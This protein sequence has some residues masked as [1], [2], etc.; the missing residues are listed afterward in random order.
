MDEGTLD[1]WCAT[2]AD[3]MRQSFG[4]AISV[5]GGSFAQREVDAL[6]L[7]NELVRGWLEGE[8]VRMATSYGRELRVD[9]QLYREHAAGTRRYHTL[10]G[11]VE[12]H[13]STYRRA[14]VH[15]GPTVVP[16]ELEAGI[17]E[18]AT[19]A[20]ALSAAQAFATMPLRLYE[21]EMRAAHRV[22]P[23]RSTVERIAKRLGDGIH[24]QLH[25]I[26]PVVRASETVPA[27][28]AS[29]SV[30]VDRTT[31]PM[32]EQLPAL[33][34]YWH[35]DRARRPPP[36]VVMAYRMAY[37]ATVAIVDV[38]GEELV[39]KRLAATA[40]EGPIEM[41]E[42]LGAEL[43]HI[44]RERPRLPVV[45]VQDGAPELWNLV[46]EWFGN[47]GIPIEM[48]LLDRFHL[49]ERL[50]QVAEMIERDE[51]LRRRLLTSWRESLDR[52]D[53]A[54]RGIC[55]QIEDRIYEPLDAPAERAAFRT[56]YQA[57]GWEPE[58]TLRIGRHSGRLLEGHVAYCRNNAMKMRYATAKKRGFPIG[59]GVTEGACKSVIASRL[60]RSGQ[61]WF[62]RGASTCLQ[63]RTLHLND[64]LQSSLDLYIEHRRA[65]LE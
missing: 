9:G 31:I 40:E 13:R 60:K 26:E 19:P 6:A 10:C 62:E 11:A 20:L 27:E 61:R 12:V 46:E 43:D 55:K 33:P 54:I 34:D 29:I 63:M 7:A 22:L 48:K 23:S 18:N 38:D 57:F 64:R 28:A 45:V 53:R 58:R 65:R 2:S 50:A 4:A 44:L 47:F 51:Q 42:R 52:S 49:D 17:V 36:P 14:G 15:N 32:A 5:R 21:D 30:G 59:S 24:E 56:F 35:R 3:S 41:M 16:L 8:L 1:T 39:T 37:V 25:A